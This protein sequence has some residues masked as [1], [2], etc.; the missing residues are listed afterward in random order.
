MATAPVRY[1][2]PVVADRPVVVVGLMGS[3]KT[4]VAVRLAE[5]LGMPLRDSDT[6]LERW[7]GHSAGEQYA[8][9]G[10]QVLHA[11]EAGQLHDALAQTPP[12]V[13]AAAASVVDDPA[14][15][16]A[17]AGAFVVW[18]HASPA[19]LARRI[20]ARD[21]RPYFEDDPHTMLSRQ[22]AQRAGRLREVADLT[23]DVADRDPDASADDVLAAL[24]GARR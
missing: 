12:P 19:V 15:R 8:H 7:Y 14:C 22:Y 5:E 18:L 10:V 9:H 11:R 3:G 21:H 13:V 2:E 1:S 6:D 24:R 17:L 23:V 20:G 4:S 16:A